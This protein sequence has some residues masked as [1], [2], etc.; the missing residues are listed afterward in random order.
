MTETELQQ[1]FATEALLDSV[2]IK[3]LVLDSVRQ[4]STEDV[5]PLFYTMLPRVNPQQLNGYLYMKRC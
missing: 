5:L 2:D 3:T 4:L 1:L